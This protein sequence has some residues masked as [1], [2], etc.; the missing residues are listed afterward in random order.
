MQ[1]RNWNVPGLIAPIVASL[2]GLLLWWRFGFEQLNQLELPLARF[3]NGLTGRNETFD[4][5][6]IFLNHF[7]GEA[8]FALI[9]F[10]AFALFLRWYVGRGIDWRPAAVFAGYLFVFWV[11][12]NYAGDKLLVEY[13]LR[14]SPS[15]YLVEHP[16][17][18]INLEAVRQAEVKTESHTSFPSNHGNVFFTVFFFCLLRFGM[19]AW[20]LL[21]LAF[22]LSLPRCFVG[23]H[24]VSDTMIGSV[25]LTWL[26][27][28]VA[29]YTPLFRICLWAEELSLR[30]PPSAPVGRWPGA[31]V[32]PTR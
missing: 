3:I 21:P 5:I 30:V 1:R 25:L 31:E 4:H 27:A 22:L 32:E 19:K 12:G 14:D 7:L 17:G 23:A 9:I 16:D 6:V 8:L 18:F 29:L 28:A 24:W 20:V 26:V 13:L 10:G 2:I 15:F 11:I